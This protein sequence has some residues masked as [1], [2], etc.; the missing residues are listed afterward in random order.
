M[1]NPRN[2][3]AAKRGRAA[4]PARAQARP[5]VRKPSVS[6]SAATWDLEDLRALYRLNIA[7]NA[8]KL[9]RKAMSRKLN[10]QNVDPKMFEEHAIAAMRIAY[11][12]DPTSADSL[13]ESSSE[14]DSPDVGRSKR[15]RIT[16]SAPH[17]QENNEVIDSLLEQIQVLNSRFK[18]FENGQS[19]A[20]KT[21]ADKGT[22]L[23]EIIS[24]FAA[25][26]A[27]ARSVVSKISEHLFTEIF[28]TTRFSTFRKSL[29]TTSS[30]TVGNTGA[31][32]FQVAN[33]KLSLPKTFGDFSNPLGIL[34]DARRL[35]GAPGFEHDRKYM[36]WLRDVAFSTL[37]PLGV[38]SLDRHIRHEAACKQ[39]PWWPIDGHVLAQGIMLVLP[40][41]K[42]TE[43]C[44]VCGGISHKVDTCPLS[45]TLAPST[46][47]PQNQVSF[48]P[49]VTPVKNGKR[50]PGICNAFWSPAGVCTN[51]GCSWS[52]KCSSCKGT[53]KHK[54]YCRRS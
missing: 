36:D 37:S 28:E 11:A 39:T 32:S 52:H 15:T 38:Y 19:Q 7:G 21:A 17:A 31:L 46:T 30:P 50:V 1:S 6:Y 40:H 42:A 33:K 9:S 51:R 41:I 13:A 18:Q 2:T 26:H 5:L 3:R 29:S 25:D 10:E 44:A 24:K 53:N 45:D 22:D 47:R 12:N 49:T 8:T 23:N 16:D 20:G 54:A 27:L 34:I 4:T 43:F 35:F 48:A 14:D